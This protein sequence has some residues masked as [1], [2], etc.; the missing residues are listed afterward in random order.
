MRGKKHHQSV[1]LDEDLLEELRSLLPALKGLSNS[2]ILDFSLREAIESLKS[3][4][5]GTAS[6]L[7]ESDPEDIDIGL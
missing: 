3:K 2:A 7:I 1:R 4:M 5:T 6:P